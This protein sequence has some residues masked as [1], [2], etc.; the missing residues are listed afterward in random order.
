MLSENQ[1]ISERIEAF[2][3]E[4]G[5]SPHAKLLVPAFDVITTPQRDESPQAPSVQLARY[6][7]AGNLQ[8]QHGDRVL[9]AAP[10]VVDAPEIALHGIYQ[11]AAAMTV[12]P[13]LLKVERSKGSPF[14]DIKVPVLCRSLSSNDSSLTFVPRHHWRPVWNEGPH[15]HE[16]S[17]G[18]YKAHTYYGWKTAMQNGNMHNPD[19]RETAMSAA[20]H[21][22]CLPER[23]YGLSWGYIDRDLRAQGAQPSSASERDSVN[24]SVQIQRIFDAVDDTL[25]RRQHCEIPQVNLRSSLLFER[26][27][28]AVERMVERHGRH[29]DV[30][31]QATF[32][33]FLRQVSERFFEELSSPGPL[34]DLY[35]DLWDRTRESQL[36]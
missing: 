14:A 9:V 10:P 22:A 27:D 26:Y 2:R 3:Q 11:A 12:L 23:N 13:D 6:M 29:P 16:R 20:R 36:A 24:V 18:H 15:D 31:S 30:E 33:G 19:A 5:Q 17:F 21:H 32:V 1:Q 8:I 25:T 4:L 28:Q 34:A 7:L 35:Q